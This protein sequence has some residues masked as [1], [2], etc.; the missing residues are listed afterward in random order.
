MADYYQCCQCGQLFD[1]RDNLPLYHDCVPPWDG[2]PSTEYWPAFIMP[3]WF[4][5]VRNS[6]IN[7]NM[8]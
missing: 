2:V 5:P 6:I 8:L 7:T 4:S 1:P 3:R